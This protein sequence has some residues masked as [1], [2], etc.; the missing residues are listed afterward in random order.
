M[1]ELEYDQN[2][3]TWLT[4]AGITP[5]TTPI[6]LRGVVKA[7]LAWIQSGALSSAA[8]TTTAPTAG[9]GGALPATPAGYL[10]T[11]V[12]GAPHKIPYY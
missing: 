12:N 6:N 11:T 1:S 2:Y 4:N 8:V 3:G 7:V 9:A 10:T 5:S